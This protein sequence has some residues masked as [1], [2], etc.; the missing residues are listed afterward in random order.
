MSRAALAHEA[1]IANGREC[2]RASVTVEIGGIPIELYPSDPGFCE[3]L[4]SRYETFATLNSI[5][6]EPS[7]EPICRFDIDLAAEGRES[8]ENVRVTRDGAIW[9]FRRGDF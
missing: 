5:R 7:A 3:L 6:R 1:L 9:N 8:D 2:E 4:A